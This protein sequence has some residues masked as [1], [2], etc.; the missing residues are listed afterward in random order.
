VG[1]D[2][3]LTLVPGDKNNLMNENSYSLRPAR[4]KPA[5]FCD[6]WES[7]FIGKALNSEF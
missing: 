3:T 7:Y 2:I 6:P 5:A 1:T 4:V